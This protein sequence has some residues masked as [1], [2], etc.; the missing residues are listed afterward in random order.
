MIKFFKL[1]KQ[2]GHACATSLACRS[3]DASS[4]G[5]PFRIIR[6]MACRRYGGRRCDELDVGYDPD[7]VVVVGGGEHTSRLP[8]RVRQGGTGEDTQDR[9]GRSS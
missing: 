7:I 3:T 2:N 9:W 5:I 8:E 1:F 6:Y 4:F